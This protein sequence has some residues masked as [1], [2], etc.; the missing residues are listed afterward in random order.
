MNKTQWTI[1]GI[2][3]ALFALEL[4]INPA[5]KT[6]AQNFGKSFGFV[7]LASGETRQRITQ[8]Q[9]ALPVMWLVGVAVIMLLA[10]YA[11]RVALIFVALIAAGVVLM[12][13]DT[14]AANLS[15]L[16]GLLNRGNIGGPAPTGEPVATGDNRTTGE[17]TAARR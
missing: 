7:P 10:D 12:H 4:G 14:L 15:N 13:G 3:A 1:F 5:T 6:W 16:Q 11:P 17:P 9:I 8:D 2:L